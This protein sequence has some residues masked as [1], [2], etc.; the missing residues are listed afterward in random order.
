M[1]TYSLICPKCKYEWSDFLW[2]SE[3][4]NAV[5]P[6]CG[7]TNATFIAMIDDRYFRPTLGD[8]RSWKTDKNRERVEKSIRSKT[9]DV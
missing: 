5:C 3:K 8:L 2:V 4:D 1:P 7:N 6:K 9:K